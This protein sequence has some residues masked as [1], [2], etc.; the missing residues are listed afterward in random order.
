MLA[1]TAE[2]RAALEAGLVRRRVFIEVDGRDP[3]TGAPDPVNFWDDVGT[4]AYDAR[5]YYGSGNIIQVATLAA[6][7]DL[8]IPALEVTIS[9]IQLEGIELA[10]A[11]GVDQAPIR[12]FLGLFNPE[13]RAILEPRFRY[14][15]GLIDDMTINTPAVGA[16]GS[17]VF[18]CMSTSRALTAQRRETRSDASCR[19]RQ[20][21]DAFYAYTGVQRE[22]PLYFGRTDPTPAPA[23]SPRGRRL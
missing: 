19:A 18:Q 4:I 16:A 12:V 14:F 2:Q 10:R 23:K 21:A 3:D 9:D 8:T 15:K 5:T 6:R 22:K 11:R 1:V 17:I 7:G 13:S 20:P